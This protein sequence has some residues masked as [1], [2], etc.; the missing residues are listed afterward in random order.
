MR[1]VRTGLGLG[2][3]LILAGCA[4]TKWGWVRTPPPD[5]PAGPPPTAQALVDYL[6]DN[7]R[8]VQSLECRDL[9]LDARQGLQSVGLMGQ[10]V[11]QKPR[12]FR[13]GANVAGSQ[14]VDLGSNDQEFW[15]WIGKADPPYLFHCSYTD[16]PRA[17]GR[18]PFPFQPDWMIEAM[19]IAEYGPAANYQVVDRGK[20]LELVEQTVSAR[21]DR[22][23]KVTVFNR[24]QTHGTDPQVL[25]HV[26][27]DANGKE[28]CGAYISEVQQDPATGAV[29]PRRIR[30]VYPAERMELKL[31]LDEVAVNRPIDPQR[32]ARLFTRPNLSNVQSFDLA[33]DIYQAPGQVRRVRG[34]MP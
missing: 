26:L 12:N 14:Q 34:A 17:S 16:F 24:T 30:L 1:Y 2:V 28:I 22:V 33:R 18:L 9:N 25:A 3:L 13:M 6:N 10:L 20:T 21:G 7:A 5:P 4:G 19:G 15:Y 27:Q 11:C 8:R 29:L 23:R 31:K 32:T